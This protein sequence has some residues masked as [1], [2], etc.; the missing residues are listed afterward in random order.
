[1][2]TILHPDLTGLEP[3][4]YYRRIIFP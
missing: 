2:I 3:L 1:L 4:R